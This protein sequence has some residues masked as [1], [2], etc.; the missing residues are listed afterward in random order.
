[1]W[2]PAVESARGGV[3]V[4]YD[5]T[6]LATPEQRADLSDV[7]APQLRTIAVRDA[8]ARYDHGPYP[9]VVFSHGQGGIRCTETVSH[10]YTQNGSYT[11]TV[12][13]G[14]GSAVITVGNDSSQGSLSADPQSGSAPLTTTFTYLPTADQT[15][16]YWIEFGDGPDGGSDAGLFDPCLAAEGQGTVVEAANGLVAGD[17]V[18]PALDVGEGGPDSGRGG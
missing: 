7:M 5:V 9:L 11:A 18:R 10:T 15:G 13:N 14:S 2:Y 4:A 1:M 17:P 6:T 8:P 12:L 3:G 16:Q